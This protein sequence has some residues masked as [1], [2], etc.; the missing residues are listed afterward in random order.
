MGN[1]QSVVI[2]LREIFQLP[3]LLC[4]KCQN[5]FNVRFYRIRVKELNSARLLGRLFGIRT[6][7]TICNYTLCETCIGNMYFII[8]P[9]LATT[10]LCSKRCINT[11]IAYHNMKPYICNSHTLKLFKTKDNHIICYKVAYLPI[12]NI[13]FI[14]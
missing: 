5:Y 2:R 1:T 7:C 13:V 10:S 9:M 8:S 4:N 14:L 11:Y 6:N 12:S 3:T